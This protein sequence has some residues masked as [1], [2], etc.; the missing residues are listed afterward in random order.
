MLV[1]DDDE[2]ISEVVTLAL[3]DEGYRVVTA[4]NG[5]EAL[6]LTDRQAPAVVLLDMLMP[7]MDGWAFA[8]AYRERGGKSPLVVMTAAADSAKRAEEVSADAVLS[9]PFGLDQLLDTVRRFA[10]A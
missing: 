1:V 5:A 10:T 4:R 3:R 6:T 9:K 8:R 7:V 2:A